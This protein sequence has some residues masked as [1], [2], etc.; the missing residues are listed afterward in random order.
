MDDESAE[1]ELPAVLDSFDTRLAKLEK[2]I[3]PLY[4]SAQV[5]T[6]RTQ[7]IDKTL[8]KIDEVGSQNEDL[9]VEEA[10]ILP[11]P[12]D[13]NQASSTPKN[14]P[15]NVS[16]LSSPSNTHHQTITTPPP[17]SWKPAPRS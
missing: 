8:L 16:T 12:P 7:N 13:P 6:R 9:D 2:S 4:T 17:A 5:L 10:L 15:S 11:G 1:I 14:P 3:L